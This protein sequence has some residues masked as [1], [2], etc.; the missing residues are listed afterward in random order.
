M[1]L[2]SFLII[3]GPWWVGSPCNFLEMSSK[4]IVVHEQSPKFQYPFV[5]LFHKTFSPIFLDFC[6]KEW[7][8]GNTVSQRFLR[9]FNLFLSEDVEFIRLVE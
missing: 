6:Q 8:V 7:F 3:N 4:E 1:Q 9:F 5:N 2:K